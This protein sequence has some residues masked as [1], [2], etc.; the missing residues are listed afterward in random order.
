M[1]RFFLMFMSFALVV[2]LPFS[3]LAQ[4]EM[5]TQMPALLVFSQKTIREDVADKIQIFRTYPTTS[6]PLVDAQIAASI[7]NFYAQDSLHLPDKSGGIRHELHIGANIYISGTK[8]MGFLVLSEYT[9]GVKPVFAHYDSYLFDMETGNAVT[10]DDLLIDNE[11]ANDFLQAEIHKQ[12][13]DY[14]PNDE[15]DLAALETLNT[16]KKIRA[17]QPQ[18]S[19]ATLR[20]SFHASSLYAGRETLMHVV[21]PY[22][23]LNPYMTPLAH[24][25]TDNSR[26]PKVALTF[27]DGGAGGITKRVIN[28][29]QFYGARATFFLVGI[30][31]ANNEYNVFRQHNAGHSLQDHSW[32]HNYYYN[33]VKYKDLILEERELFRTTLCELTGLYPVFMRAPGGFEKPYVNAGVEY[34]MI[35]WSLS[36]GDCGKGVTVEKLANRLIYSTKPGDIVLMHDLNPLTPQHLP[37]VLPALAA[38]GF[39]FLTVDE[40][41]LDSGIEPQPNLVYFSP[42]RYGEPE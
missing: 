42:T 7:D 23:A 27:D 11:E 30:R 36:S 29:L 24:Q 37:D 5:Y 21:I 10:I 9:A 13:L 17:M 16:V 38:R 41:L 1:K 22:Q 40:L 35:H 6:N 19:A 28:A 14:Y 3:S 15:A 26:Y 20:L 34:P 39:M 31:F 18:L 33:S 2:F 8:M 32:T 25:E 4:D 12:L